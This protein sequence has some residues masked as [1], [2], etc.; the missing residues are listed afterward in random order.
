MQRQDSSHATS[1]LGNTPNL[2]IGSYT[3]E[4]P[5]IGSSDRDYYN[6]MRVCTEDRAGLQPIEPIASSRAPCW[7]RPRATPARTYTDKAFRH[8]K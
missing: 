1:T 6:C 3:K 7:R 5:Y 8:R 2:N 4:K